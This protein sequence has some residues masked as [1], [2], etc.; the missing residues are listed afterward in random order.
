VSVTQ[1]SQVLLAGSD[2]L[3]IGWLL[4][5][6]AVVPYACTAKLVQVLANHPQMIMQ[7]AAPA[8]SEM[9]IAETRARLIASTS[10][11]TRAMLI[12][13]GAV[14]CGVIAVNEAFVS[15]WVGPA[16]YGGAS[17]T[18]LLIAVMVVRHLNTT[19]VYTVFCFGHERRTA[20]TSLGDG[21]VTMVA[22]LVGVQLFGVHGVPL[23]SLA[24]VLLVS[25]GP[26]LALLAREL[27]VPVMAPVRDLGGWGARFLACAAAAYGLAWLPIEN[28]L[29]ATVARGSAIAIV[30]LAVMTPYVRTGTLGVYARNWVAQWRTPPTPPTAT[31]A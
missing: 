10:A 3:V 28:P 9:R 11:L 12:L 5:P 22:S 15:W 8:L 17:L 13:S 21:L 27:A 18:L 6:A 7:A 1:V 20:L 4:G 14:A 25:V 31:A 30:Y 19:T 23:G 26:N 29:I 16:Q 2:V 24:G